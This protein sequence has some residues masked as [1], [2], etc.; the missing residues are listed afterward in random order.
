[1]RLG[2]HDLTTTDDGP[3]EDIKITHVEKHSEY[4]A[5]INDIAIIYLEHDVTFTGNFTS[6]FFT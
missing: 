2:E 5:R 4:S 6:I 1:M 3:H